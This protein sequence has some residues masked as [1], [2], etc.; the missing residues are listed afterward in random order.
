MAIIDRN[1]TTRHIGGYIITQTIRFGVMAIGFRLSWLK[2][3]GSG[4]HDLGS[5]GR[6]ELIGVTSGNWKSAG[7]KLAPNLQSSLAMISIHILNI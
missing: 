6:R 7:L 1:R 4:Q 5:D 3:Q 2:I